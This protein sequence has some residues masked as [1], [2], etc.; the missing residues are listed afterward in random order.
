M[1]NFNTSAF[2]SWMQ[3][4]GIK[5]NHLTEKEKVAAMK[6]FKAESK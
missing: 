5:W 6:Q 1:E 2:E 3:K 4:N